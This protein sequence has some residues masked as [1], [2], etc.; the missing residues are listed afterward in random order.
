MNWSIL[1]KYSDPPK[2]PKDFLSMS[3]W[4]SWR[5]NG[6]AANKLAVEHNTKDFKNDMKSEK[7]GLLDVVSV[8]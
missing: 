4:S 6:M 7:Y 2:I 8:D 3:H 5:L 1:I